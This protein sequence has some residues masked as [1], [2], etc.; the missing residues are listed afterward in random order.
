M[1][2]AAAVRCLTATLLSLSIAPTLLAQE[3]KSTP[4]ARQLI[5]ALDTAKLDSIA[6]RDPIA[7]DT[8]VAALYIP[9]SPLL[10]VSAKYTAPQLLEIRLA[11]KE[12]RDVYI[13]LS[14]ASVPDTKVFIQDAGSDGMKPK[15]E[16]T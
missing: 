13:D 10:I 12:F 2:R 1:P 11:K 7:P 15:R 16:G 5:A 6:A 14:S 4:L 9:G 8:Y 3:S